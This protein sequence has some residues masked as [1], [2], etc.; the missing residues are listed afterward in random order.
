VAAAVDTVRAQLPASAAV[1]RERESATCE[2]ISGGGSLDFVLM[3]V[4]LLGHDFEVVDPPELA[5][6]CRVLA[7]KLLSAARASDAS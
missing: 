3:H 1:V 5:N 4:V 6:R 2:V 7:D